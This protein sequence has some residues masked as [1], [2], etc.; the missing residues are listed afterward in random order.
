MIDVANID[1]I[2]GIDVKKIFNELP[3][4]LKQDKHIINVD[5]SDYVVDKKVTAEDF[6]KR[7]SV[8]LTYLDT[9]TG[10]VSLPIASF[11]V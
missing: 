3:E 5:G 10:Q 4:S 1:T 2:I 8:T 11:L 9:L 6:K 7:L